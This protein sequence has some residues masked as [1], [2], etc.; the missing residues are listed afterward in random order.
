MA[1]AP[2]PILLFT[3]DNVSDADITALDSNYGNVSNAIPADVTAGFKTANLPL[4]G[5]AAVQIISGQTDWLISDGNSF[6]ELK[7]VDTSLKAYQITAGVAGVLQQKAKMAS[8]VMSLSIITSACHAIL[9][10]QL[11]LSD[12]F[13]K[14]TW[15]DGLNSQL[16]VAKVLATE[17][18]NDLAPDMTATLPN[19]VI[20][21]GTT[22]SAITD[23]IRKI[24]DANPLATGPNDP[25]VQQVFALVSA[26]KTQVTQIHGDAT[27][28]TGLEGM[29][30]KLTEWGDKMQAAHDNLYKG[31]SNIQAAETDLQTDIDK[32]NSA[33]EGLR[34]QIDGEN[35]AIAAAAAAIGIG[36]FIAIIGIALIATGVGAVAGGVVTALGAGAVIG[37]AVTWGIMQHRIN[38][39]FDQIAKDQNEL[40]EDKQQLVALQGLSTASNQALSSIALATSALSAVKASWKLF[41]GELQGVLDKLNMTSTGLALIV[42]EAFVNGA[43]EEWNLAEQ[44]A[45]QLISTPMT[46]EAKTLSMQGT[47]TAAAA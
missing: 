31:V 32:M 45:Q 24:S 5:A 11:I 19:Q 22:Y 29:D 14:P 37:G 34:A 3:I 10:T 7:K 8:G 39:Q 27:A 9:N 28:K 43:E 35:K 46:A 1:N 42:N 33:I 21:Y 26:L 20:N 41:E 15:F 6:Y 18:L 12:K 16:D 4:S 17:W 25:S 38:E 13:P 44:F 40:S 30:S 36:I 47:A 2:Q 23:Q